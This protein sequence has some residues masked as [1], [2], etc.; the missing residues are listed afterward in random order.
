MQLYETSPR[1]TY[2]LSV[3][4]HKTNST[5]CQHDVVIDIVKPHKHHSIPTRLSTISKHQSTTTTSK[6]QVIC[7]TFLIQPH[8]GVMNSSTVTREIEMMRWYHRVSTGGIEV[9][10]R[11]RR[12]NGRNDDPGSHTLQ[13]CVWSTACQPYSC[14]QLSTSMS[15][16]NATKSR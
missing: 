8:N 7:Y 13:A 2:D 10:R 14:L 12:R 5:T 6:Q 9:V 16:R 15:Y 4:Q 3:D 1:Q 11:S